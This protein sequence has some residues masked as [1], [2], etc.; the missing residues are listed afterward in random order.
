[1]LRTSK[2][3]TVS[4]P[5]RLYETVTK[6]AKRED[7]TK[8]ELIREALRQYVWSRNVRDVQDY[9]RERAAELGITE[10]DLE[11]LVDEERE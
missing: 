6:L 4:M 7:R 10:D 5:P 1:M 3:L 8:S 9:G 11:T 2:L